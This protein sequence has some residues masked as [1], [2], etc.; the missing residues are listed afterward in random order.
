MAWLWQFSA[1]DRP[2]GT[3]VPVEARFTDEEEVRLR[4]YDQY[5]EDLRA[6]SIIKHGAPGQLKLDWHEEKG[7]S[8]TTELPPDEQVIALFHRLRPFVL[9][10][11]DTNFLRVS[12][13]IGR[14]ACNDLIRKFLRVQKDLYLGK[15][16]QQL[17]QVIS[18]DIVIN[19]E[20]ILQKWLNAYEY[21]RDADKRREIE[22]LHQLIPLE[23]S[24][25]IFVMMLYDKATAIRNL[26][27]LVRLILGKQDTWTWAAVGKPPSGG[28]T[29]SAASDSEAGS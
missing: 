22:G 7:F 2:D 27:S 13:T 11:E 19:S 23:A 4:A 17:V 3:P 24:R 9:E 8:W 28:R 25:A 26:H 1:T 18:N 15:Y 14:L 12:S 20:A 5:V 21:H 29:P 6:I 10:E 16:S